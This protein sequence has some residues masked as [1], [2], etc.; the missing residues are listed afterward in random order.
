[1]PNNY[2]ILEINSN[3]CKIIINLIDIFDNTLQI[4]FSI[5][6]YIKRIVKNPKTG[7]F[8]LD[9]IKIIEKNK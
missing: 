9:L 8:S 3:Q 4:L 7:F 6:F 5:G 1:M 2:F